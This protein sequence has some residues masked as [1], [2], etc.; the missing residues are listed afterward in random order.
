MSALPSMVSTEQHPLAISECHEWAEVQQIRASWSNLVA[1]APELSIFLTPEWMFSWWRA[2]GGKRKLCVLVFTDP[3]AGVVGIAPLYWE[4][5]RFL[6]FAKLRVLRLMGDGSGD[7]DDLDFIVKPGYAA[8]VATALLNWMVQTPWNLCEFECLSS[9]SEVVVLLRDE[10]RNLEWKEVTAHRPFT[11]VA[12]PETW[13]GYLKQLSAKERQKVGIRL[14]RLQSRHQVCFR[15]CERP[16]EI[17]AF[18]ETLFSLHQKRWEAKGEPGSFSL[19]ERRR[20]YEEMTRAL[21]SRGWLELWQMEMDGVPVAAQIGMRYGSCF[22]A[23]QEGFDPDY[24][25]DSVGY[26]L[27][28]QILRECIQSGARFY[29]FLYGD[30]ASKQRWGA[31]VG[32]Y[33][34][35]HFSRPGSA[36]A[37]YLASSQISRAGKDWL[38]ER[39]PAKVWKALQ[40]LR[41]SLL[42]RRPKT[43]MRVESTVE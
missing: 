12:L 39:A 29:D 33:I 31:D 22:Y 41:R 14:R 21:L 32:H 35:I 4:S 43:E 13:E 37:A 36:G 1:Q 5:R 10:L 26:V 16:D 42:E 17:P 7:S 28:S 40:T 23:L 27:R 6:A 8:E 34:D 15:R 18:L 19:S 2:Y 30:Q 11:R 3:Q 38:R 24:A 20:F 9:K 25:S